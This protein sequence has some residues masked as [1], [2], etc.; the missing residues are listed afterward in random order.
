VAK[1]KKPPRE[2]R[3]NVRLP[4]GPIDWAAWVADATSQPRGRGGKGRKLSPEVCAKFSVAQKARFAKQRAALAEVERLRAIE[5]AQQPAPYDPWAF[6]TVQ[7]RLLGSMQP[8]EWYATVDMARVAPA[9]KYQSCKALAVTW[10]R[11][12][13]LERRQNPEWKP[14]PVGARQEPKWL[15]ALAGEALERHQLAKALL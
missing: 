2:P 6:V 3:I 9:V 14:V 7:D 4:G 10:W 12:G 11:K 8:G 13:W 15:Y 5:A 1:P